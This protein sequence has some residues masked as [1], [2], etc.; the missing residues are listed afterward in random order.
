MDEA[1]ARTTEWDAFNFRGIWD[2]KVSSDFSQQAKETIIFKKDNLQYSV[3][4]RLRGPQNK[5]Q[6]KRKEK[7]VLTEKKKP[8]NIRE[9][10]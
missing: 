5:N 6:R 1:Q 3:F 9:M 7:Q 8:W 2:T 10:V 4:W